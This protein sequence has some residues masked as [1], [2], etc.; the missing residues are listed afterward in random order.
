MK[1]IDLEQGSDA[2]LQYRCTRVTASRVADIC[3]KTKSGTSASRANYLAELV[4]GRLTGQPSDSG[5]KSAAMLKGTELEPEAR[6]AYEFYSGLDVVQVGLV[7]HPT[8]DM[9]ACSPDGLVGD[10]GLVEIKAPLVSTHIE[11]LLSEQIPADYRTQMFWQMS[12]TGRAWCDYVS[13]SPSLPE[14][15]RLF[16]KRVTRDPHEIVRLETEVRTFLAELDEKLAALNAK[17]TNLE[18]AA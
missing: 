6:A 1:I 5:F 18:A 8:I 9:A 10:V 13:Y 14:T 11:T 12:C 7:E 4:C 16:V 15:M 17:F 2:W 3:R